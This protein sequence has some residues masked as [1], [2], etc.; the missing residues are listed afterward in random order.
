MK[1]KSVVVAVLGLALTQGFAANGF[2]LNTDNDKLSYS[3]GAD[4]GMNLKKNDIMLNPSALAQ[5]LTDSMQGNKLLLTDDQMRDVL[6]KFQ[7]DLMA[8]RNAAFLKASQDNKAKGDAFLAKNKTQKGVIVLP[9]GL[10]Y[11]VITAGSGPKPGK[12]DTVTVDY[13]GNTIDGTVFDSTSKS[14]KPATFKVSQVIPGWTEILQLMPVGS[15]WEVYIPSNLAYGPRGM[16]G[17]IGPNETLIFK[18]NLIGINQPQNP[19]P[20][21]PSQPQNSST[22]TQ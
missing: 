10:Q 7:K 13:T 20:T 8:K 12:D 11:K 16:G 15:T 2:Q 4:L 5:G 19:A 22:N 6:E 17:P 9:S 1:I 3:I 18:I 14:G 21:A